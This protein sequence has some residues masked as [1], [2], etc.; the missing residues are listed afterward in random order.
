MLTCEPTA[1][2]VLLEGQVASLTG[3]LRELQEENQRLQQEKHVLRLK[4]DALSRKLFGRFSEKLNPDQLQLVFDT[5][6]QEAA[7]ACATPPVEEPAAGDPGPDT[8]PAAPGPPPAPGKK[9]RSLAELIENLPSTTIVLTPPEVEADPGAWRATGASEETKLLDYVPGHFCV[10]II[11]RP[12]YVPINHPFQ[13]PITAPLD[14]IQDRCI[15]TPNIWVA[16]VLQRGRT[17]VS[18]EGFSRHTPS[19]G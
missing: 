4:I 9:K 8:T 19:T 11:L 12:K 7:A 5:L 2:E 17:R 18:A 10:R 1:R 13:A 15:A 14:L 3:K 6:A 16:L